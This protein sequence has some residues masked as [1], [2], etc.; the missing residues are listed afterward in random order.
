VIFA[1]P[2]FLAP[3]VIEGFPRLSAFEYSPWL[4]ANLTLERPPS[5]AS[6]VERAWDNVVMNSPT[7]GYVD[8]AHQTVRTFVDRTV[9]TFYWALAEYPA[10]EARRKLLS[11]DWNY[12]K[13][14]ILTDLER[15]HPDIRECV[16]R[17]DIMRMGHAMVRPAPRA[18]FAGQRRELAKTSGRLAF[19]NSD[20]SGI[21]IFEEAQ[22]RGV[23]AADK[24]IEKLGSA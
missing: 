2:T 13:E 9:W 20:L 14:A 4:T 15:V 7:L 5:G 16:S 8:A 18:L 10:T 17:I 11:T 19:A 23:R 6:T 22:Y 3:Y 21:S 1:A 24:I 12:W